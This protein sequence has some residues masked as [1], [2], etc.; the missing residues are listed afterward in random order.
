MVKLFTSASK[1]GGVAQRRL[2]SINHEITEADAMVSTKA[3]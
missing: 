1:A 2:R 3:F